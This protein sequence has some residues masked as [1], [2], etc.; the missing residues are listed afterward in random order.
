MKRNTTQM[1][2]KHKNK[3]IIFRKI[4]S[5]KFQDI[6]IFIYLNYRCW[7]CFKKV[8]SLINSFFF[9]AFFLFYQSECKF[10]VNITNILM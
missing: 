4:N 9:L 3:I 2:N 6:E 7:G 8:L 1:V 5:K 10:N